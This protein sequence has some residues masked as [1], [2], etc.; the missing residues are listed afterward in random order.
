M[1]FALLTSER[2]KSAAAVAA[3]VKRD[4]RSLSASS[5]E[6]WSHISPDDDPPEETSSFIQLS[7]GLVIVAWLYCSCRCHCLAHH[8]LIVPLVLTAF[9]F[10]FFF[11]AN[12]CC[13]YHLCFRRVWQRFGC[14]DT[15]PYSVG[16]FHTMCTA[17]NSL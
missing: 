2:D 11:F 3:V 5:E 9:F 4:K 10:S 8:T 14:T 15:S 13:N 12:T 6:S 16:L 17:T 1:Q 7:E